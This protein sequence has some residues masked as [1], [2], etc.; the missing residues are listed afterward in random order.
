MERGVPLKKGQFVNVTF[1]LQPDDQII[2]AG[3]RIALMILSSDKEF[4]LWP[5]PGTQLSVDLAGTRISVPVV[6]GRTA[7][8]KATGAK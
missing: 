4:T 3:K 8:S 7:F 2:P 6:G 5:K 1:D